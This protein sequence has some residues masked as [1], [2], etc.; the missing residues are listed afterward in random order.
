[1]IY[2]LY[3]TD[4]DKAHK[5]FEGLIEALQKKKPDASLL[6]FNEDNFEIERIAELTQGQGLFENKF[7]VALSHVCRNDEGKEC[8][9][10]NI[11]DIASSENIFVVLEEKVD[12]K[13]KKKFETHSEKVQEFEKKE[14]KERATFNRFAIA[15]A[16]GNRSRKDLW[17]RYQEALSENVAPEE[18]H[19][20][21]FWQV[22]SMLSAKDAGSP[23]E[24]GLK[25]F[26]F[27]KAKSFSRNFTD[28]EL[29]KLSEDL[30]GVYHT[31]RRGIDDF[32]IALEKFVLNI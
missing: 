12:A 11:K 13:T 16:L 7:I 14:V 6:R 19:G 30:V 1:M 5:K 29:C 21:L 22:K 15:D 20:I 23:E 18:I 26:P 2:F 24:A 10:A 8:I 28:K 27:K 31:A 9:V 17:F 32:D 25:P 3:G 4:F